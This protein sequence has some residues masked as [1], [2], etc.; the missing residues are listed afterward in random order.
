MGRGKISSWFSHFKC[1]K[2]LVD[3]NQFRL[4]LN[5]QNQLW[6]L[7]WSST[8]TVSNLFMKIRHW[9]PI[10]WILREELLPHGTPLNF[11]SIITGNSNWFYNY[12]PEISLVNTCITGKY[13]LHLTRKTRKNKKKLHITRRERKKN[14]HIPL[15]H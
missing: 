5:Q 8:R 11:V 12:N 4:T 1:G 15:C 6:T 7:I 13:Q 2:A 14:V 10:V 3:N 9:W